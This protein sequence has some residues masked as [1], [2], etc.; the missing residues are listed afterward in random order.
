MRCNP[1]SSKEP[2]LPAPPASRQH[3]G[4]LDGRSLSGTGLRGR[5]AIEETGAY[6]RPQ[7]IPGPRSKLISINRMGNMVISSRYT[8]HI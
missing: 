3:S 2:T 1:T 4:K 5:D 8:F 6:E 7:Y